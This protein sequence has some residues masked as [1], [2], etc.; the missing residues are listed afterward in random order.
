MFLREQ[1]AI[2]RKLGVAKNTIEAQTF[3]TQSSIL[4]NVQT[5]TPFYLRGYEAI[6]TQIELIETRQN[7]RAFIDGLLAL[8]QSKRQLEQD[9]TLARAEAIFALTPIMNVLNNSLPRR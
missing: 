1:A 9:Q 5:D 3:I 8:E 7:K 2:A 4:A 6:E